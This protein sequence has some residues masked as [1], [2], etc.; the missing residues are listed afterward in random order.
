[1]YSSGF[2]LPSRAF[3]ISGRV[4]FAIARSDFDSQPLT[5]GTIKPSSIDTAMPMFTALRVMRLFS[6]NAELTT[7]FFD[8]RDRTRLGDHVSDR[9]FARHSASADVMSCSRNWRNASMSIS[10]VT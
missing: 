4:S 1:V 5:T 6:E 10:A 8:Q 9:D 7:G 3:S 2:S